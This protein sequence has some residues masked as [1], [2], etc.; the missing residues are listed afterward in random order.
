MFNWLEDRQFKSARRWS[1]E[2]LTTILK[3]FGGDVVNVSAWKDAD[4][5]GGHYRD[6]FPN[7]TSYSWTNYSGSCGMQHQPNEYFLDLE[8]DVSDELKQRFDVVFNHTTLE[9]VFEVRKAFRNLCDMSR[10]AVVVVVPFAQVQHECEG[11]R[12]YWRFTPT[13][14]RALFRENGLDVIYESES[15]QRHAAVYLLMIGSR[16]PEKWAGQLPRHAPVEKAA[17]WLGASPTRTALKLLLRG[18][19]RGLWRSFGSHDNNHESSAA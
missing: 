16:N 6:Y 1:N 4:K 18:N 13:C 10:D 14:L 19:L 2:E 5:F 7:A 12:D 15:T 9:H 11:Y 8:G 3:P 17:G